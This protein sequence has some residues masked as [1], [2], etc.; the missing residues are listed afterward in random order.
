MS[1]LIFIYTGK[2]TTYEKVNFS[3]SSTT[4]GEGRRPIM[5][6]FYQ[7][8]NTG[9]SDLLDA[10]KEV[11]QERGFETKILTMD[12][13]MSY[14]RFNEIRDAIL[15]KV[16]TGNVN[17]ERYNEMCFFRWFAMVASG[18]GWMCD[19]DVFPLNFPTESVDVLPNGGHFTSY[20]WHVPSLMSGSA[21]EWDR[22][23]TIMLEAILR[24]PAGEPKTDMLAFQ[25]IRIEQEKQAMN[26]NII[27]IG[28]G[29]YVRAGF[30][31][32]S[33]H[34]VDCDLL[35]RAWVAHLSHSESRKAFQKDIFPVDDLYNR[36][37]AGKLYLR[38][39][40]DQCVDI[41]GETNSTLHIHH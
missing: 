4:K 24:I 38:H 37:Q 7:P 32:A 23:A 11:W 17:T 35:K 19:Y 6:T 16:G 40:K 8:V 15:G 29:T 1:V 21:E 27:F 31:Y 13:A 39:W 9:E 26:H 22:V 5:H 33:M 36:A 20:E 34:V 30:D 41:G 18:G 2:L 3:E 14:P 12:D 10:W 28:P 25:T